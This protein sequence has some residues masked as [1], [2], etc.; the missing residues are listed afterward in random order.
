MTRITNQ[1]VNLLPNIFQTDTNRNFLNATIDQLT[2]PNNPVKIYGFLG[3]RGGVYKSGD[4]Y[5]LSNTALRQNYQLVPGTV[6]KDNTYTPQRAITYDDLLNQLAFYG[7]D[8]SNQNKLFEQ[9]FYTY[10]PPIDY[11]KFVNYENYYWL[12]TGP[13]AIYITSEVDITADIL[14]KV[15]YSIN[16]ID[17]MN[18]LK[19][20]FTNTNTSPSE[21]INQPLIVEGVGTSIRLIP[22]NDLVVP[23][24]YNSN[25]FGTFDT[26]PYDTVA[27]DVLLNAPSDLD[28]I[29]INRSSAD[30]NAWSRNNRWFH[31]DVVIYTASVNNTDYQLDTTYKAFRPIIEFDRDIKLWNQGT[32]YK[33]PIDVIDDSETDAFSNYLG[34]LENTVVIDGVTLLEGM[35]VIFTADADAQFVKNKTWVV[36]INKTGPVN[37]INFIPADDFEPNVTDNLLVRFGSKYATSVLTFD[38][39]IWA[40]SKQQKSNVQQSPMFDLFDNDG[41]Q[42]ND[43]SVYVGSS[44]TGN[45]IFSYTV[46]K[47]NDDPVLGFPLKYQTFNGIGDIVFQNDIEN[48]VYYYQILEEKTPI[49]SNICFFRQA[50]ELK[51]NYV[52]AIELSKQFII[53]AARITATGG[54][55]LTLPTSKYTDSSLKTYFVYRNNKLLVENTDYTINVTSVIFTK[56]LKKDEF[57]EIR[58]FNP[59]A[60]S[61][62]TSVLTKFEVPINLLSDTNNEIFKEVTLGQV[63]QHVGTGVANVP[64]TGIYPGSSNLKDFDVKNLT[65]LLVRNTSGL[66]LPSFVLTDQTT[67][68][69]NALRHARNEYTKYKQKLITIAGQIPYV[70]DLSIMF[71]NVIATITENY[72]ISMPFATSDMFAFGDPDVINNYTIVDPGYKEFSLTTDYSFSQ[73]NDKS[74]LVYLTRNNQRSLL[75]K[76]SDYVLTNPNTITVNIDLFLDDVITIKEYYHTDGTYCPPTPSKLGLYPTFEPKIYLDDTLI[77]PIN[78]IQ[79]HDGSIMPAYNDFRDEIILDFERRIY[80]NIKAQFDKDLFDFDNFIPGRYRTTYVSRSEFNNVINKEFLQ[81]A[82]KNSVPYNVNNYDYNI[83]FTWNFSDTTDTETGE[84]LPGFWRGIYRYYYDTDR[85]HIC[86]WESLGFSERPVWWIGIYGDAPYTQDNLL[87]WEDLQAGYVRGGDSPGVIKNK[88]RAGLVN[89]IPVDHQGKLLPPNEIGIS[90]LTLNYDVTKSWA[91]SDQGPVEST[92]IRSSE[93]PFSL[94]IA[95]AIFKPSQYGYMMFDR[96]LIVKNAAGQYVNKNTTLPLSI[97]DFKLQGINPDGN[98]YRGSGYQSYLADWLTFQNSDRTIYFYDRINYMSSNL[99]FKLAGY[100]D[101][102]KLQFFLS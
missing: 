53:Y 26:N 50:G 43:S 62:I 16:N 31:K 70:S 59:S 99:L 11:D 3:E 29:T 47:G 61:D 8:I 9:K 2:T 17:F 93:Y 84:Q 63:R 4:Q 30:R 102:N 72:N 60:T 77:T 36:Q 95:A 57:I 15:N 86:P 56:Y 14:G 35:R 32:L 58:M 67:N 18:G 22:L 49:N 69:I 34:Q 101:N 20:I 41:I 51:N 46:G 6:L 75:L 24:D 76:T 87:L 78:V 19:V 5:L 80:N 81:W 97:T 38:G 37:T 85:P 83:A 23:E 92:W 10:A 73:A 12:L 1:N 74:F 25:G 21:F 55:I 90:N 52:E 48:E 82:N 64:I 100:S 54:Y 65:N 44:F 7:V 91:V 94:Q 66:N 98:I 40:V 96:D 89:R 68:L 28:Y 13:D 42:L 27:Y 45:K 88:V 39:S 71:D 79:G 33:K